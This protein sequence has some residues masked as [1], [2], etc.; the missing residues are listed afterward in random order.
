SGVQG[1][2]RDSARVSLA[3]AT[4]TETKS[5]S[6]RLLDSMGLP[7]ALLSV[8]SRRWIIARYFNRRQRVLSNDITNGFHRAVRGANTSH[9]RM[10]WPRQMT[11]ICATGMNAHT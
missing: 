2:G 10:L 8:M 7:M 3:P 9:R 5:Q 1:A 4:V 11:S 6:A